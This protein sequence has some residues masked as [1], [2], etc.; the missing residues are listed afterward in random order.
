[1]H[2]VVPQ[3]DRDTEHPKEVQDRTLVK[4]AKLVLSSGRDIHSFG[5]NPVALLHQVRCNI[6]DAQERQMLAEN[7]WVPAAIFTRETDWL[8]GRLLNKMVEGFAA[9]K[10]LI[11]PIVAIVNEDQESGAVEA[12]RSK[13]LRLAALLPLPTTIQ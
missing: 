9:I 3:L 8:P 5:Y 10:E 1:M 4:S 7:V 12:A 2:V 11:A 13:Q 6:L